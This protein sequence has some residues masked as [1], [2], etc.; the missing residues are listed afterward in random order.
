MPCFHAPKYLRSLILFLVISHSVTAQ[1]DF[2]MQGSKNSSIDVMFGTQFLRKDTLD[3]YI[4]SV[5]SVKFAN[6]SNIVGISAAISFEINED[7]SQDAFI[8]VQYQLPNVA[9]GLDSSAYSFYGYQFGV[10]VAGKDL[11]YG[12]KAFDLVYCVGVQFGSYYFKMENPI[13]PGDVRAKN[14]VIAPQVILESRYFIGDLKLGLKLRAQY[15]ISNSSWRALDPFQIPFGGFSAT[16]G[17]AQ[18]V[19]GYRIS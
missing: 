14:G 2:K 13:L 5:D 11:F 16:G 10:C 8:S 7:N 3:K 19:V 9:R 17:A 15:D 18:L 1:S 6:Y 4:Y 12:K